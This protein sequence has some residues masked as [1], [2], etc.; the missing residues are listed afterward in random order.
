MLDFGDEVENFDD[1]Q[2]WSSVLDAYEERFLWDS[3]FEGEAATDLSPGLSL[4]NQAV[5]GICEDSS[6]SQ[7]ASQD[8]TTRCTIRA[9]QLPA[10]RCTFRMPITSQPQLELHLRR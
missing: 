8:V 3:D 10:G 6:A 1:A 9:P 2:E 5:M 7:T 4:Q